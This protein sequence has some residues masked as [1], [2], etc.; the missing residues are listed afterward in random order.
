MR[1]CRWDI[2]LPHLESTCHWSTSAV[3]VGVCL[4]ILGLAGMAKAWEDYTRW[5]ARDGLMLRDAIWSADGVARGTLIILPGHQEFAEKYTELAGWGVAQSWEVRLLEWR[6]Q[7][8]SDRV[9]DDRHKAHH[10]DFAVPARDFADWLAQADHTLPRP[11]IV[12]AHSLGAHLA[13]RSITDQP[14]VP[15]DGLILAAPMLLPATRPFPSFLARWIAALAV[16][17]GLAERF[18]PG[19]GPYS[20]E[21]HTFEGNPVT[22]DPRRWAVHHEHFRNNSELVLGGVTW[23]WLNAA[24]DSWRV[25]NASA[26]DAIHLPVLMLSVPNDRLVVSRLHAEF[27]ARLLDCELEVFPGARHELFM[28]SDGYRDRVLQRSQQFLDRF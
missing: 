2:D 6:G 15:V 20:W 1:A 5:V 14:Q 18:A 25:I 17:L 12:V 7:G 26:P 13:L 19:Q 23:G 28:E 11:V 8:L 24:M 9:L 22:S 21:Q 16:R 3:A 4:L 10:E 27:C